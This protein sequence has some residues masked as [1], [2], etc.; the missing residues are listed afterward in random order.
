MNNCRY[1]KLFYVTKALLKKILKTN[2]TLV[3]TNQDNKCKKHADDTENEKRA[4]GDWGHLKVI[5]ACG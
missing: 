1:T 3:F 2:H 4:W 5:P